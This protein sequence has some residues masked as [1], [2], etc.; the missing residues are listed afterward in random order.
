M[1][2][3]DAEADA[4]YPHLGLRRAD[5]PY[6]NLQLPARARGPAGAVP[7]GQGRERVIRTGHGQSRDY[8]D[9]RRVDGA[10]GKGREGVGQSRSGEGGDCHVQVLIAWVFSAM[11][12]TMYHSTWIQ[13]DSSRLRCFPA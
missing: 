6:A 4:G 7:I 13:N 3:V 2:P 9:Q 8:D 5:A 12:G 1:E 11:T 10:A